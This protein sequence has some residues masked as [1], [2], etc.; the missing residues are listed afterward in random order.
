MALSA[1]KIKDCIAKGEL[2]TDIYMKDVKDNEA[3]STLVVKTHD[4]SGNCL[5]VSSSASQFY[6]PFL[7]NTFEDMRVLIVNKDGLVAEINL[8]SLKKY[9]L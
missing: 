6:V 9:H 3:A 4:E 1:S 7:P 8:E 5:T 2:T